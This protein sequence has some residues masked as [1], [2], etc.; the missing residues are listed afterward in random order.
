MP[1][2]D[3]WAPTVQSAFWSEG[4]S[5]SYADQIR[6]SGAAL[7]I[8]GGWR[9]EFRDQGLITH[10]NVP[11]SRILIGDWLHCQNVGFALHEEA[12]RFFDQWLKSI[13]TGITREPPIHYYT[14]G[15]G[16][17]GEWRTAAEWPL[18][19]SQLTDFFLGPTGLQSAPPRA[20]IQPGQWTVRYDPSCPGPGG[21]LAQP[22]HSE[23]NGLS[24]STGPLE[25]DVELTGHGIADLWIAA[26]ARDANIFPMSRMSLLTGRYR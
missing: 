2:R 11:G 19:Q 8:V 7:Y 1:Y 20:A 23:G 26:P 25:S 22:C 16:S 5:S 15:A 13:D 17:E 10:L 18:P 6:R 21:P 9:D 24:F 3:T 14:V 4:S 12:H